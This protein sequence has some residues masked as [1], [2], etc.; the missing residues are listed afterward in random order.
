VNPVKNSDE[1]TP[2]RRGGTL[3]RLVG[4]YLTAMSNHTPI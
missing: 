1:N 4:A 3:R 2:P